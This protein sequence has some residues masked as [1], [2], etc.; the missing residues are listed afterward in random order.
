MEYT[1]AAFVRTIA[2]ANVIRL[3]RF[4][5]RAPVSCFALR[6][7]ERFRFGRQTSGFRWVSFRA[8]VCVPLDFYARRNWAAFRP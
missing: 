1:R 7:A 6:P 4:L 5:F 8:W 3:L 2:C